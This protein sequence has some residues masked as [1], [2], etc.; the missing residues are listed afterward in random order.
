MISILVPNPPT[1][2]DVRPE[3][4]TI[5]VTLR[6]PVVSN[7]I[8]TQMTVEVLRQNR[9][10]GDKFVITVEGGNRE[11][12]KIIPGLEPGTIYIVQVLSYMYSQ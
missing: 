3:V 4:T 2:L 5:N 7:G 6:T 10:S 9:S 8:L 12:S 11:Y 1:I